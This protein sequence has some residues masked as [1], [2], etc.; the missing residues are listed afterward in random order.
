MISVTIYASQCRA[1]VSK[2]SIPLKI[3]LHKVTTT[4]CLAYVIQGNKTILEL[5]QDST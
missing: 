4:V 5:N 2:V 3:E 1:E